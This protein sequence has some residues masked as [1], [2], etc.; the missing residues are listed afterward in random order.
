M[1]CDDLAICFEEAR[2]VTVVMYATCANTFGDLHL[3]IRLRSRRWGLMGPLNLYSKRIQ[4]FGGV[5]CNWYELD[6]SHFH[7]V[8]LSTNQLA[9]LVG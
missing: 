2:S 3:R 7:H 1:K 8:V 4:V 6:R 9:K 5:G